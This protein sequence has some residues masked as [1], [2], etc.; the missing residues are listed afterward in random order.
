LRPGYDADIL[1]VAGDPLTD[2]VALHAIEAVYV[3]G[4]PLA[5]CRSERAPKRKRLLTYMPTP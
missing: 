2:Q 5:A 3:R 4:V 1:A